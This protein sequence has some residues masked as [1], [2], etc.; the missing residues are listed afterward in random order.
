L[1]SYIR[2]VGKNLTG[3]SVYKRE[4]RTVGIQ[5][6][7]GVIL[8]NGVNLNDASTIGAPDPFPKTETDEWYAKENTIKFIREN[9]SSPWLI[10]CSMKKPH[11]PYQPPREYWDMID[12]TKL[13]IPSYP[14]DDLKDASPAYE[15]GMKKRGMVN[16]S[17]EQILDGMQ[18]YYGNIAF[19][20]AMFK[21]VLDELDKLG[22]KE[23]TLIIYTSDH[24]EMLHDHGLWTKMVFFD[25]SVRIPLIF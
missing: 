24:G 1:E 21:E 22:L 16:M 2:L 19:M 5:E 8:P 4:K 11:P 10:Q 14:K 20:D 7:G 13:V 17:K 18:G 3:M 12:R 9:T 6:N 15:L 25:A 23:N